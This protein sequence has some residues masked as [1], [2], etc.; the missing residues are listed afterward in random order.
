MRTARSIVIAALLAACM[1]AAGCS[2]AD[3]TSRGSSVTVY[4]AAGTTL[5]MQEI[6]ARFGRTTGCAVRLTFAA[7]S[8]LARQIQA[9]APADLYVSADPRWIDHLQGQDLIDPASRLVLLGN[10]LALVTPRGSGRCADLSPEFDLPGTIPGRLAVGEVRNVPVGRYAREALV[11]MGWWTA[12]KDRLAEAPSTRAAL[13]FVE[14]GETAAGLV[15]RSDAVCSDKVDIVGLIPSGAHRPIRF[16]L[17]STSDASVATGEFIRFLR[18]DEASAVFR[19]H[20]FDPLAGVGAVPV[21]ASLAET[22]PGWLPPAQR[23]AVFLSLKVALMSLAVMCV[24]GVAAGWLLARKRFPGKTLLDA[25]IHAPLVMPPVVT[26]YLALL[27]LGRRGPVGGWL[28]ESLG[29]SLAFTWKA[30]VVVSAVVSFP[31]LVRSVRIAIELVDRKLEQSAATLGAGPVRV[32]ATV[33]LPLA[34]PGIVSGLVLAFAR[35]LGEFGATA[36]FAG[37]IAGQTRTLPLAIYNLSQTPG[38][39]EGALQLAG[40]SVLVSIGAI[41]GSHVI[42]RRMRSRIEGQVQP[43]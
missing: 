14:T 15:Y 11:S 18:S 27:V 19:Q 23:D 25:L 6:A 33:T 31:L 10:R 5:A 1:Q 8:K 13:R 29:I 24:P 38:G 43:C 2:D 39:D 26:G 12:M 42:T 35:S 36:T 9:G 34:L 4:A 28:C 7:S 21:P 3:A 41:A 20:G 17:V 22:G 40:V 30:A 32:L 37:N 16:E